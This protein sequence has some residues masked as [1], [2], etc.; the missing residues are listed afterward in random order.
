M[1]AT[2]KTESM[3][4]A[5]IIATTPTVIGF[6]YPPAGRRRLWAVIVPSC[7]WC[8]HLHQ[9]RATGPFGGL[10]VAGCGRTYRVRVAGSKRARWS[11]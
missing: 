11:R 2:N 5:E 3:T 7:C 6:A 1:S 10:R 9:H 8:Q 4:V